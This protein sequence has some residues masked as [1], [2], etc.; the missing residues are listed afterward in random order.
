MTDYKFFYVGEQPQSL[1]NKML[2][3]KG[4]QAL[5]QLNGRPIEKGYLLEMIHELNI[6]VEQR[7]SALP[8]C[9]LMR[10]ADPNDPRHYE[11]T[12]GYG[13]GWKLVSEDSRLSL[14]RVGKM[15][16]AM[17]LVD[18]PTDKRPKFMTTAEFEMF[19]D[20]CAAGMDIENAL[21]DGPAQAKLQWQLQE[22]PV[23]ISAQRALEHLLVVSS[24]IAP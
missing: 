6:Q 12:G 19:L 23:F 11:N 18:C 5:E 17:D 10:T 15:I 7:L 8:E 13:S 3:L 2:F 14:D 9:K 22:R 4:C 20:I 1:E 16:R 24:H 21:T